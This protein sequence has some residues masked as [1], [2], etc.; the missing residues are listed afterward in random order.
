MRPLAGTSTVDAMTHNGRIGGSAVVVGAS[1]AGLCAARVLSEHFGRVTVIDRDGL[2]RTSGSRPQVPQGQHPHLLLKAGARLLEAWFPGL[3]EELL[4]GGA[5][6]LDL[7]QDLA[8]YQSG[9]FQRR[10][11]STLHGPMMSRPFLEHAVRRRVASLDAVSIVDHTTVTALTTDDSGAVVTG[12]R[13]DNGQELACDLV[14]DATGRQARSLAWLTQRGYQP[15]PISEVGVDTRYV[16]RTYSRTDRPLRDWKAAAVIG[17]PATRRFAVALPIEDDRWLVTFQGV[18]G[19]T[20]PTDDTAVPAYARSFESPVIAELLEVS[21]Q[22]SGPV[23]YRF[24]ANQRRHVERMR[25][26]SLGLA[27]AGRRGLQ[28]RPDLRPGHDGGRPPGRGT[29]A[30]PGPSQGD[31]SLIRT[32]VLPRRRPGGGRPV[33]NRRR[34]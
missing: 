24:A 4:A 5:I 13:L 34:R 18:N 3:V 32:R 10:P 9:G 20:P 8:W 28:L 33:V 16:T 2:P 1:M 21:Q 14:V 23:T 7:C 15:P 31:R 17:E 26:F 12:V 19:E 27:A 22:L 30:K 11:S 29:R 6:D 25:R